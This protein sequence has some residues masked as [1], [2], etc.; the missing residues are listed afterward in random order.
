MH[1][2]LQN[3]SNEQHTVDKGGGDNEG[4]GVKTRSI[5]FFYFLHNAIYFIVLN[6]FHEL[7]YQNLNTKMV[8]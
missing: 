4:G 5:T 2:I 6:V 7:F 3:S 1:E 8:K